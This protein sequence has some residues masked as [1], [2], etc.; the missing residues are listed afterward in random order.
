MIR[1]QQINEL[2]VI[3]DASMNPNPTFAS[4]TGALPNTYNGLSTANGIFAKVSGPNG[5]LNSVRVSSTSAADVGLGQTTYGAKPSGEWMVAEIEFTHVAGNL[6]G[7]GIALSA[8]TAANA[9]ILQRTI[10]FFTEFGAGTV[11]RTYRVSK[12]LDARN[13]NT[14]MY[15]LNLWTRS[16]AF[17]PVGAVTLDWH[18]ASIRP[19]TAAEIAEGTVLPG[20]QASV[21][22]NSLAI[23]DLETGAAL[24]KFELVAAASGGKP[25]RLRLVSSSLVG[26]AIALDAEYLYLGPNTVWDTT[27]NTEQT[28]VGSRIRVTAKGLPFGAAGNLL[29]WWGPTGIALTDMT[30]SN[31]YN[32][33]MTSAPYVFDNVISSGAPTQSRIASFSGNIGRTTPLNVAGSTSSMTV[34]A[35]GR[36]IVEVTNGFA[37]SPGEASGLLRLYISKNGVETQIGSVSVVASDPQQS[38]DLSALNMDVSNAYAGPVSFILKANGNGPSGE[39]VGA[40]RGT[41][42]A[43]W[44]P[45]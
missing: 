13:V 41:L 27:T 4:W 32:G 22:Q 5:Q 1:E 42:K 20:L 25:A 10:D 6:R 16:A 28:T 9:F 17:S 39:Q 21:S 44:Y 35:T 26:S 45:G 18:K 12:L 37:S 15:G 24:A 40:V 33:R 23:I 43:T 31:G 11:G 2:R 8:R 29:E 34:P 3:S 30:T 7:S 19:A 14:A 38:I 36:F